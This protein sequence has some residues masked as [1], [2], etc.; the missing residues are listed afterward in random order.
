M[1]VDGHQP[2]RA[3]GGEQVGHQPGRD[4]LPAAALL[5]LARVA[6]ERGDHRDAFRRRPLERVH[7][8]QLLHDPLVDRRGVALQHECITAADRLEEPHEDLAVREVVKPGR[9]RLDAKAAGYI[10]ARAWE[11]PAGEEQQLLLASGRDARHSSRAP[12]SGGEPARSAPASVVPGTRCAK[13]PTLVPGPTTADSQTDWTT[14]AP[15]A[16]VVSRSR[17]PGPILAPAAMTVRPSSCVPGPISVSDSSRTPTS[18][19]V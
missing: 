1:Q 5:V 16:T 18:I 8:D 13:G 11:C 6:E 7:H 12:S 15:A 2:V 3:C 17:Q 4:R 19:Q 9:R 10:A 14:V